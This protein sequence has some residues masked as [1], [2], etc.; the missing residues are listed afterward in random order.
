LQVTLL[1]ESALRSLNDD[2][3]ATFNGIVRRVIENISAMEDIN[4]KEDD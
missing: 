2:D 1:R 3:L 4:M